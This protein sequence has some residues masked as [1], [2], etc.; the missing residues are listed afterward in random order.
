MLVSGRDKSLLHRPAS[1]SS[2]A[3]GGSDVE[4]LF[5][6]N[7]PKERCDILLVSGGNTL[8]AC[9][10]WTFLGLDKLIKQRIDLGDVVLCGGSAGAMAWFQTGHSDSADS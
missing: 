8:Y 9:D 1:H 3:V 6:S 5:I 4:K 7:D 2:S 10:R